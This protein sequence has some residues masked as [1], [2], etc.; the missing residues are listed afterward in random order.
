[1]AIGPLGGHKGF[2]LGLFVALLAG[3]LT[4][5]ATGKALGT[6][7]S[8]TPGPASS[9][10]HLFIA[11][12]P[13]RFGDVDAFG[14]AVGGTIRAIK[15]SR[16]GPAESKIRVAGERAFAT[17]DRSIKEGRVVIYDAVWR[18]ITGLAGELGVAMPD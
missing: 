15:D 14:N 6:W 11:I 4:G 7:L 10:G 5:S 13:A 3:P 16:A 18:M 17:R 9:T 8:E 12:D 1:M 2:G